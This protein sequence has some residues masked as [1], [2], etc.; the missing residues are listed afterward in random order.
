[1]SCN[2]KIELCYAF[3]GLF[4]LPIKCNM[5]SYRVD[6]LACFRITGTSRQ[7]Q[8]KLEQSP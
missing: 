7:V 6:E 1:M 8:M 4:L 5:L 2:S 3:N